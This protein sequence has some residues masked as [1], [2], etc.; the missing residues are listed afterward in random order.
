[1]PPT[2]I[3]LALHRDNKGIIIWDIKKNTRQGLRLKG[4]TWN[5]VEPRPTA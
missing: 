3:I 2:G 1:L 4:L 5:K